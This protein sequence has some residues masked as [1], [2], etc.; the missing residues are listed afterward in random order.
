MENA[1]TIRIRT[2][3]FKHEYEERYR[4]WLLEAYFPLL[5]TIP[6]I[7]ELDYYQTVKKNPIYAKNLSIFHYANQ[8]TAVEIRSDQ[9][10]KDITKD[11]ETWGGRIETVWMPAYQQITIIKKDLTNQIRNP[12]SEADKSMIIHMEGYAFS[13]P[14]QEIYDAWIDKSGQEA[15]IPLMMRLPGLREFTLYKLIDVD[16]T[17]LTDVFRTK[18]PVEYPSRLSIL[19]FDNLKAFDNYEN[20]LELAAYNRAIEAPFPFGLN[21]QWYVQYQLVR[22]YKK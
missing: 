16:P 22:S 9:R 15:F 11:A 8:R 17:G 10:W 12:I 14:E 13:N 7:E 5:I 19:T 20:S 1:P 4:N 3:R 6:G 21:Y 2:I 18:R